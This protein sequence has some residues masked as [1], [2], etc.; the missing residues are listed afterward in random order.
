MTSKAWRLRF[1]ALLAAGALSVHELRFLA[2]FGGHA[3]HVAGEQG[4]AYLSLLLP[5]VVLTGL[6]A[7]GAY[8]LRIGR[9]AGTGCAAPPVRTVWG[10]ASA[11]LVLIYAGQETLEGWLSTGH[12]GGLDG[13]LGHGGWTALLFAAAI[14]ALIAL[15]LR[16]AADPVAA[17]TGAAWRARMTAAVR[18]VSP[19]A[20]PA[21]RRLPLARFLGGRGPP[22]IS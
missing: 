7:L 10:S 17:V 6:V 9:G 4:H 18:M 1:S 16:G 13:V 2:E 22:R 8:L 15:A 12:P 11:L 3:D 21:L 14:G 19:R 20:T 5:V